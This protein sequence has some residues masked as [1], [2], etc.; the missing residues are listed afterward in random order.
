MPDHRENYKVHK[1]PR[2][3]AVEVGDEYYANPEDGEGGFIVNG[4]LPTTEAQ[5]VHS[6]TD[7]PVY[8]WGPCQETFGGTFNNIDIFYKIA[9]C[10]GLSTSEEDGGNGGDDGDGDG[11]DGDDGNDGDD[12]C[13][14]DSKPKSNH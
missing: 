11:D 6:L 4:T 3:P 13:K 2:E 10:L 8:A 14:P 5:G 12:G 7:V 1:S 9:N